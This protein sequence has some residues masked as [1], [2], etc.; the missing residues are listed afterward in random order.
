MGILRLC[1]MDIKDKITEQPSRFD[2]LEQMSVAE[3]L[4]H[5]NDEDAEVAEAVRQAI[6]TE[7]TVIKTLLGRHSIV[8]PANTILPAS[9][10]VLMGNSIFFHIKY[11]GYRHQQIDKSS[12]S[13]YQS[14]KAHQACV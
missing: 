2:H 7:Y 9:I 4:Q 14:R 6:S 12:I 8:L 11:K 10:E 13:R 1:G 3:L 5:I